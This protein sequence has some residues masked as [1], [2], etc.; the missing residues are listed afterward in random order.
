MAGSSSSPSQGVE[1]HPG[2]RAVHDLLES[3]ARRPPVVLAAATLLAGTVFV[4]VTSRSLPLVVGLA[5][6]LAIGCLGPWLAVAGVRGS[7]GFD[8][9]RCRVG[10]PVEASIEL[11]GGTGRRGLTLVDAETGAAAPGAGGR[12][13]TL[14]PQVRGTFPRVPPRVESD[15]PFGIVTARRSLR[16]TR[17]LVAWPVTMPVRFPA[18]LVD[19]CRH[20]R[21]PS[22]RV[23]GSSGDLLGVRPYRVGD[24]ARS[25]H[26]AHTARHDAVMVSERPGTGGPAVRLVVDRAAPPGLAAGA[27]SAA[28]DALVTI[29][30]S[31]VESWVPR[32]VAIEM[33]WSGAPLLRPRDRRGLEAALDALACLEPEPAGGAAGP[34]TVHPLDR[35]Q[36]ADLEVWLT[37]PGRRAAFT[38]AWSG[39]ARAGGREPRL[40]LLVDPA[41]VAGASRPRPAVRR[42]GV[43]IVLPVVRS[44]AVLDRVLAEIGHDP[45]A[46][47]S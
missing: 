23:A 31:L 35:P 41:A 11:A 2:L 1:G 38:A 46:I 25:I 15:A 10:E 9:R 28:L 16:V 45:D 20:G 47:R 18:A 43:E 7:I 8:R 17:P 29:A 44:A 22:D 36:A 26:W 27:W 32:G 21:E 42:D 12:R 13:V 3:V 24:T 34:R 19:P 40:V 5:A 4:L 30:A 14:V 37:T 33:A 6:V 39:P